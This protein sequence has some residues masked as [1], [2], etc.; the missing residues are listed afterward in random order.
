[1]NYSFLPSLVHRLVLPLLF[2]GAFALNPVTALAE[3]MK[4]RAQLVWGT[5]LKES[6]KPGHKP[7]DEET[8]E[9]LQK[10]FTWK[11]YF[12]EKNVVATVPNR[13][14]E[15][16]QLS[17]KCTV[18]IRELPGSSVE[19]QLIG[20]GRPVQNATKAFPKGEWII[21]GGDDRNECAWFVILK[22]L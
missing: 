9:K 4:V 15:T 19:I 6:K 18:K 16:I 12:L 11:N 1:M 3:E 20:K 21:I 5:N 13:G 14:T 22:R 8:A 2:A 10:I 7:V 17:K